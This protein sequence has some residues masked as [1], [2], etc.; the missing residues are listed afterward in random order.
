MNMRMKVK[1]TQTVRHGFDDKTLFNHPPKFE[2]INTLMRNFL[3]A[4]RIAFQ[5]GKMVKVPQ[6]KVSFKIP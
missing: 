5:Y 6:F 2:Y 3:P 4:M 1:M